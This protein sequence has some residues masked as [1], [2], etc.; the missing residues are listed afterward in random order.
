MNASKSNGEKKDKVLPLNKRPECRSQ[1]EGGFIKGREEE[2]ESEAR[3]FQSRA[4]LVVTFPDE[5]F[6]V[7]R[8]SNNRP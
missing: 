7:T 2:E 4:K 3:D 1:W 6:R 5:R 8:E